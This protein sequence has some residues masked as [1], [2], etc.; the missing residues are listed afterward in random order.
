MKSIRTKIMLLLFGSVLLASLIIGALGIAVTAKIVKENS[1]QNMNLLCKV[2]ADEIDIILAKIEDSV[3]T[4]AHYAVEELKSASVLEDKYYRAK[5]TA[6]IETSAI[7]HMENT[8]DAVSVYLHYSPEL[9]GCT[10]GFFRVSNGSD[11][12]F[13]SADVT[14]ISLYDKEDKSHVGWWYIPVANGKPTWLEAYYNENINCHII[15][16]VV[17]LYKNDVLVGVIGADISTE[18]IENLVEGISVLRTGR[19]AL[20]EKDGVVV[21]HPNFSRGEVIG[22]DD[23]G[24]DGVV[25][26]LSQIDRTDELISY[27]MDGIDKKIAS[28]KLRNGMLMVCFAPVSEIYREQNYL[29]TF[30]VVLT[31]IVASVSLVFAFLLSKKLTQPIKELN[32]AAK[33]LTEGDFAVNIDA[34]GSDEISEL[35]RTFI[36]T[37][38]V[39]KHQFELLDSEAHRDGLTGVG[40]KSAFIDKEEFLTKEIKNNTASFAVAV[41]DVNKLKITNDVFG[42]MAGDKLLITVSEHLTKY[43]DLS[44]VYRIGGDEYVVVVDGKDE[45]YF[46]AMVAKCIEDMNGLSVDGYPECRVSCAYGISHFDRR[47]DHQF[48][49][50]LRQADKEMYKNKTLT[51]KESF[52]WEDGAKGLKKIQIEKYCELLQTLSASTDDFLFILNMENCTLR[53]FGKEQKRYY[54]GAEDNT[55]S[56]LSNILALVHPNDKVMMEKALSLVLSYESEVININ[57]RMCTDEGVQWVNC[58][59]NVIKEEGGSSYVMIGRIS[60]N[61]VKHLYNPITAL[62]NK[63]KLK[64]DLETGEAVS[65]TCLMLLDIDNLSE[66]NLMH[67]TVHG[68]MLM[69][70]LA[71]ELEKRFDMNRVFHSEKDRFVVL[72]NVNSSKE[73][74]KVFAE[75][76]RALADKFTVSAAVVPNDPTLYVDA[77][78]IYDYAVQI[79][80]TA[81][82]TGVDQLVFFSKE[83]LLERITAVELLEEIEGCAKKDFKGLFLVYQPQIRAND[84]SILS[85]EVLLR[86]ESETKGTVYPDQFIPI[87]E[88]TGL[89]NEVGMWVVDTALAQCKKWRE[90]YPDFCVSVN[91]SPIQLKKKR[92][93]VQIIKAVE[94][95]GLPGDALILEIT[96]NAQ[97]DN[98]E[99][100]MSSLAKLRQAGIRIAIDDF[101]TGYSNLGHLKQLHADIVKVDRMFVRDIK[102]N[103]YNYTLIHN[104]IEFA[105]ANSLL[106]ALEGIETTDELF[107]LEGLAPH[108]L[109]G[110]LF[111]RPC[112][113]EELENKYFHKDNEEYARR[114]AFISQLNGERKH[115]PII[116]LDTKTILAGIDVGLWILRNDVKGGITEL[117]TDAALRSLLGADPKISPKECFDY[118]H[119]NIKDED[120]HK[121]QLMCNEMM[122]SQK[123]IQAE[124]RWNHPERGEVVVRCTGRCIKKTEEAVAFE[125]FLRIVSDIDK[126]I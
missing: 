84:Y 50:V 23:S 95:H 79:L 63:T 111:D 53:L 70:T 106:V 29:T 2:N 99:E 122:N 109:Q 91:V 72:L 30:I 1:N 85:A 27:E 93:A 98:S 125:G 20:L 36:E 34:V 19:A 81:K 68:D 101:G 118:W 35:T 105:R 49:D 45:K 24:F 44:N 46:D 6:D 25:E 102:E 33:H 75:I 110:Y 88:E 26:K 123:V 108:V 31:L 112:L 38:D 22:E 86:Y 121:L 117:F 97:L 21:Y 48:S 12:T 58:R 90:T 113:P 120:E 62:F 83:S 89:I 87:L 96:E 78:N 7:H 55:V 13:V 59:G 100:I 9:I 18:R 94:K 8:K 82:K 52:P 10:D 67:G 11:S 116:N 60:S 40:N 119:K 103:G 71:E 74:E 77:E 73:A 107:V 114:E 16:Y 64:N 61:A 92:T 54:V 104:I 15:S 126:V 124:Y 47:K 41:F 66:I 115:T 76:R 56:G 65:F 57:F 28:C 17:P 69:K 32:Y 3:D 80:N 43:F 37:R 4:L 5:Y 39:L 14:D 42:H 51:K